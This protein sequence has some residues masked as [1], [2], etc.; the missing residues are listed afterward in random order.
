MM[1]FSRQKREKSPS[2]AAAPHSRPQQE[3]RIRALIQPASTARILG[4][5]VSCGKPLFSFST[6]TPSL[7][8]GPPPPSASNDAVRVSSRHTC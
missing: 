2:E 5:S 6:P 8:P 1:C 4:G 3:A 7:L